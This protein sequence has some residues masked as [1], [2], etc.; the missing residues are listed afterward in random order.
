[1]TASVEEKGT[2]SR[3]YYFKDLIEKEI[4]LSLTFFGEKTKLR[5]ACEYA[6]KSGGKRVRPLLV[7]LIAEALGN[8][9]NVAEAAV[10][11]EFFHTASLI[12]DDL[13]CMDNDDLRRN[14]PSLHKMYGEPVALLASYALMT[15]GFEWLVKSGERMRSAPAS[16]S[17]VADRAA[18]FVLN[19]ASRSSGITGATGGQFFD[20]FPKERGFDALKRVLYQKTVTLFEVAFYAGWLFGGG[21]FDAL[22]QVKESAYHFGMAFQIADDM[23]DESQ[24]SDKGVSSNVVH[25]LGR[26]SARTLFE[27]EL[28]L[29][30]KGAKELSIWSPSFEKLISILCMAS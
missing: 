17:F 25:L 5:D 24:D 6:L 22:P 19:A 30:R 12:V 21:A 4:A 3:L 11:A 7:F 2:T 18:L 20:L 16:F 8:G 29:F 13:P 9:L 15:A 27:K 28:E 1:M 10:A 14:A 23:G 26:E